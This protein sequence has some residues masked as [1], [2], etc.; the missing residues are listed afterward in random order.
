MND[1]IDIGVFAADTKD[2]NEFNQTNPLYLRKHKLTAGEHTI[3]L[4]IKGKPERVGIDPYNKLIDRVPRD[5]VKT[6]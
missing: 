1:Y 4:I 2:R 3:T 6:L 5:N